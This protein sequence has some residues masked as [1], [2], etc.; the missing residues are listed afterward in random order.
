MQHLAAEAAAKFGQ[1][2][3]V[4]LLLERGAPASHPGDPA[5]AA[6]LAW[7]HRRGHQKVAALLQGQNDLRF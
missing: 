5:W 3:M 4:R 6:P 7:A 2:R 1:L